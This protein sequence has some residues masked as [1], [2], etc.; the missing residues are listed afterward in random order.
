MESQRARVMQ[1]VGATDITVDYSRPQVKG[2]SIWG[3]LVPY[4]Q[5]WRAGANE[6][7]WIEF[8]GDVVILG[9]PLTAGKYGLHMIPGETEWTVAFNT[10]SNA[11]GSFSYNAERDALRVGVRPVGGLELMELL[12][13]TM[14]VVTDSTATIRLRW[15]KLAVDIPIRVPQ[16]TTVAAL[17]KQLD[18]DNGAHPNWNMAGAN[19]LMQHNLEPQLAR[20]WAE[21]AHS[22]KPTYNTSML[23]SRMEEKEGNT[24]R[25]EE[26]KSMAIDVATSDEIN[27]LGYQE[28]QAG[29]TDKAIELL[30]INTKR[31]PQDPNS[32][33]SL[34]EAYAAANTK[35]EAVKCF[36]K[37]LLMNPPENVRQNSEM[38]LKK[39]GS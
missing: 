22:S 36:K 13:Y 8:S 11:W 38:W 34:G 37:S 6:N 32:W 30:T 20:V 7:T 27:M 28:L 39:L 5:V 9:K 15:E 2:R 33:D 3:D 19:W 4:G 17:R 1:R 26:M 21:K 29:N 25:A 31:H 14:P 10:V 18:A 12:T 16:S 23:L 35:T 24:K